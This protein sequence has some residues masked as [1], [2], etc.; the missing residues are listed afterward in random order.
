MVAELEKFCVVHVIPTDGTGGVEV[1]ARS[2]Y[3]GSYGGI[4]FHKCYIGHRDD[5]EQKEF[6]H[7][8]IHSS[9]N[10]PANYFYMTFLLWRLRPK[11]I[12][13]SLWKS[14]IPALLYKSVKPSCSL[15]VFL[16]SRRSRH[17][18]DAIVNWLAMLVATEIWVDSEATSHRVPKR[19]Q[20][21]IRIISFVTFRM[22]SPPKRSVSPNFIFWGRLHR[23]KGVDRALKL[24][25]KF[26]N[27]VPDARYT[28]IGKDDGL[29]D[30]LRTLSLELGL[31]D[32]VHFVGERTFEEIRELSESHSFYLQTSKEEG[33]AMAVVEAMQLGLV[34]VVTPVG[35]IGSYCNDGVN[36]IVVG[37]D[38][39]ETVDRM[40]HLTEDR[41]SYAAM[42]SAAWKHWQERALY[43]EDV[44][45]ACREL[46]L[47]DGWPTPEV[48]H[49]RL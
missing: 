40:V 22:Q 26:N 44:L 18:L 14:C 13:A 29:A 24:F 41:K 15:I 19:L 21:R 8:G 23:I 10:H 31:E 20:G 6:Y 34:P 42:S 12:I 2:M 28:I 16:H 45:D 46:A 49:D 5:R 1:A 33:M 17:F 25:A 9:A 11:L 36:S 38:I 30:T 3:E 43:K 27:R 39:F 37:N 32:H 35:E 4:E 47:S 7:Q 48:Q